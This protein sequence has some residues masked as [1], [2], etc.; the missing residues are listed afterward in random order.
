MKR[1][2]FPTI[3]I[4]SIVVVAILATIVIIINFDSI[5]RPQDIT[6]KEYIQTEAPYSN[7]NTP[8]PQ[9]DYPVDIEDSFD[10]EKT[11]V[12]FYI[13]VGSFNN[14]TGAQKTAEELIKVS[15]EEIIVLPQTKEGIYRI[16]CGKYSSRL[17]ADSA[18]Q[19]VRSKIRN[20]AWILE[21]LD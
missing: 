6:L 19:N 12:Y 20:D 8:S 1:G 17:G 5:V 18:I 7:Q 3:L 14:L 9:K 21:A 13:I 16:S 11:G 4:F 2:T 10:K 15:S